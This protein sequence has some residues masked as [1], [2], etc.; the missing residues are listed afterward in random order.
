MKDDIEV[1]GQETKK[2][3]IVDPN[4]KIEVKTYNDEDFLVQRHKKDEND[5]EEGTYVRITKD[6]DTGKERI[7]PNSEIVVWSY[8]DESTGLNISTVGDKNS[9]PKEG[10]Y[11]KVKY[12]DVVVIE[13]QTTIVGGKGNNQEVD[14][15]IKQ[16]QTEKEK[17]QK[18][19]RDKVKKAIAL[20]I[21]PLIIVTG[22][23]SC[24]PKQE[25]E[26][27][28]IGIVQEV[29]SGI[30]VSEQDIIDLIEKAEEATENIRDVVRNSEMQ[31]AAIQDDQTLLGQEV[32]H[33]VQ[34]GNEL[35]I[36]GDELANDC[37]EFIEKT[38]SDKNITYDEAIDY[39][40]EG[41]DIL[42][43]VE[44]FYEN[45]KEMMEIHAK[46]NKEIEEKGLRTEATHY[47]GENTEGQIKIREK[48]I[49]QIKD[50]KQGFVETQKTLIDTN[51]ETYDA[52]KT[53]TNPQNVENVV[54]DASGKG[55]K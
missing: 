17:K 46:T 52:T 27:D 21:I 16:Q 31:P 44:E 13:E 50:A 20:V 32:T 51:S 15:N 43:R 37:E 54:E 40:E 24:Q 55:A 26:K 7:I 10:T 29:D 5:V 12:E 38:T 42:N 1:L 6:E 36:Q 4:S 30:A 9:P 49:E 11:V 34:D 39:V 2:V 47:E 48:Q 14:T 18:E 41:I 23:K 8:N 33:T 22:A 35:I 25:Q 3:K 19:I 45:D 53:N 28:P